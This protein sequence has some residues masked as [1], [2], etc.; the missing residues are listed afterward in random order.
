LIKK[1][2][3]YNGK[4]RA[5]STISAELTGC[6]HVE[7]LYITLHKTQ[8]HVVQGPQHTVRYTKSHRIETKKYP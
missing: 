6:L 5:S 7:K 1:A 2:K 3:A 4:I 8:V